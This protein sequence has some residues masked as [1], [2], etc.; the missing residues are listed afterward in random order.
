MKNFETEEKNRKDTSK[1]RKKRKTTKEQNRSQ[2][3]QKLT[4]SQIIKIQQYEEQQR[5]ERLKD[6]NKKSFPKK[7]V[8]EQSGKSWTLRQTIN[9]K[10]AFYLRVLSTVIF[11]DFIF[12][13][14]ILDFFKSLIL[15]FTYQPTATNTYTTH[16][17]QNIGVHGCTG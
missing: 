15:N 9:N 5:R 13:F 2:F 7:N 6:R 3:G 11:D 1:N 8:M 16:T 17:V 4:D 14:F 10:G 12:C